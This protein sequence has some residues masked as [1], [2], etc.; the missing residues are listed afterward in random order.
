LT[1]LSTQRRPGAGTPIAGRSSAATRRPLDLAVLPLP[2]FW[3]LWVAVYSV[4]VLGIGFSAMATPGF[5][6]TELGVDQELSRHHDGVLTVLAMVLNYVFSPVGGLLMIASMCLYLLLARKSAVNAFAFGGVA[7]AGWMSSQLF[8]AIVAR[9]RPDPALLLDPLAP[10]TGFNSFP[11]GH[12]ALAVGLAWAFFFLARTTRWSGIAA[13]AGI[14]VS[15]AVAWSRLYI[16]VHYPTDV[17]ASF[18]AATAAVFFFAG[19][20]NRYHGRLFAHFTRKD[21]G[22]K[23]PM[24]PTST[25][26]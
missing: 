5:S 1:R 12:V 6:R 17:T 2:R 9:P 18:L 14:L 7:A 8:K 23:P 4:L 24:S 26:R 15:L 21:P 20:W 19:L 16:G 11:S 3:G 25:S 22:A 10:E 13:W